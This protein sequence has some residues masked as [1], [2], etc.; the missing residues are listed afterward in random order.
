MFALFYPASTVQAREQWKILAKGME[1]CVFHVSPPPET[2][3][4]KIHIVRVDTAQAKL[5][6]LLASE[7]NKKAR[8]TAKWCKDFNL[9]I[10]I[11]AGMFQQ[12]YLTNVGYLRNGFY[13][14]NKRWSSK[15][16]SV[17]AFDPKKNGLP[18]VIMVD[19]EEPDAMKKLGD[20]NA[21]VQNLRLMKGNGIN[22]WE[23]SEKRWSEAAVGTDDQGRVLFLFCA[24]PYP[25]W[26]FNEAVKSFGLGVT[27][28]MHMEG[29][30]TASLSIRSREVNV[31]LAGSFETAVGPDETSSELSPIP[32]VIGVQMK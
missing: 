7:H 10:A 3:N 1:Y 16:K 22:V 20:Y 23:K 21:V 13:I 8:T 26:E 12:D 25:M 28:M 14:Q 18:T 27:R 17:L 4:G 6:L 24:L 2:G 19:L 9:V 29:G 15:Y 11:N 30:P 5:R 32:N 31:D